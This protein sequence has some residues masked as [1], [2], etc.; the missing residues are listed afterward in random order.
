VRPFRF[1]AGIDALTA[2]G[3][4]G[5]ARKLEDLGYSTVV[6]PD[7]LVDLPA[8]LSA[9]GMAAAVTTRLRLATFVLNNDLR[10]PAVLA[11]ELATLDRLSGGR[12]EV[13][14]GAGWNRP[15]YLSAGLAFDRS[16]TRIARLTESV[17]V[18]KAL[19]REGPV[20]FEGRFYR[21]SGFADLP[22]PLQRPHPP[23]LIG[24]GGRTTLTLAAREADIIGLAPRAVGEGLPDARSYTFAAATEKV[25]WVRAAAGERFPSLEINTYS[26][27]GPVSITDSPRT[28]AKAIS[29]RLKRR[30]QVELT[31]DEVLESPHV[32][33]GSVEALV[34][35]CQRLRE[36][37]GISYIVVTGDEAATFAPVVE[38]LAGT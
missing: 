21:I 33:V 29:D 1:G 10:H 26:S 35:K 11:Q 14:I 20:A 34:E 2:E 16:G 8:P 18:L 9:L 3:F 31:E 30:V 5:A 25:A 17:A 12:L 27:L 4:V 32:F 36:E 24:G 28:A 19:F 6:F 7:H 23:I 22:R 15:E 13:G 37:L 38:R